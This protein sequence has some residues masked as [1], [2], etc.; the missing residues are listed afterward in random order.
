MKLKTKNTEKLTVV[1][2]LVFILYPV[3]SKCQSVDECK[4]PKRTV[5]FLFRSFVNAFRTQRQP[6]PM[7]H[8]YQPLKQTKQP[9]TSQTTLHATK[10]DLLASSK[11]IFELKKNLFKPPSTRAPEFDLIHQLI[12]K[13]PTPNPVPQIQPQSEP[14]HPLHVP[15]STQVHPT[16]PSQFATH[17][18][19]PNLHSNNVPPLQSQPPQNFPTDPYIT[20]YQSIPFSPSPANPISSAPKSILSS[21]HHSNMPLTAQIFIL[22][23]QEQH[24]VAAPFPEFNPQSSPPVVPSPI[25][26]QAEIYLQ[27]SLIPTS[28]NHYPTRFSASNGWRDVEDIISRGNQQTPGKNEE[29]EYIKNINVMNPETTPYNVPTDPDGTRSKHP[30]N[31]NSSEI[32]NGNQENYVGEYNSGPQRYYENHKPA[33][34]PPLF[35]PQPQPQ[36]Q[37]S[38]LFSPESYQTENSGVDRSFQMDQ[39]FTQDKFEHSVQQAQSHYRTHNLEDHQQ[40]MPRE[41]QKPNDSNSFLNDPNSESEFTTASHNYGHQ[42]EDGVELRGNVVNVNSY[43]QRFF[44]NTESDFQNSYPYIQ[45]NSFGIIQYPTKIGR[46]PDFLIN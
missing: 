28:G 38:T 17:S 44:E 27:P 33:S 35:V 11:N 31:P 25:N 14:S 10:A 13:N 39:D 1:L 24:A 45:D 34:A 16:H 46:L 37:Q 8:S 30:D 21:N 36:V 23:F 6:E 42:R 12:Q 29:K 32:Q 20:P 22:P 41:H 3:L 40:I 2:L 43:D 18:T 15:P 19:Q 7:V 5:G 26:Y 4:R 9:T